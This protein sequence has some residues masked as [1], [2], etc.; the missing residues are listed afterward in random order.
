MKISASPSPLA[1]FRLV[2]LLACLVLA[3]QQLAL[4]WPAGLAG[5]GHMRERLP[6]LLAGS[7][8]GLRGA[9]VAYG[10]CFAGF[11]WALWRATASGASAG[12]RLGLLGLLGAQI[13]LALL[14]S[15]KLLLLTAAELALLLPLRAAAIGLA[16][17]LAL[18]MLAGGWQAQRL[19]VLELVCNVSGS[20]VQLPPR[21]QRGWLLWQDILVGG[22]FQLLTFGIGCLGAAERRRRAELESTRA[23]LLAARQLLAGAAGNGERLRMARELHDG[24]GHHLSALNL[25]LEL[26]LRRG[27]GEAD[28]PLR[29]AQQAARRMLAEVRALVGEERRPRESPLREALRQ[30]CEGVRPAAELSWDG[31]PG[32]DD[33]AAW[34]AFAAAREGLAGA[35]GRPCRLWLSARGGDAAELR[36]S[37][38]GGAEEWTTI[39]REAAR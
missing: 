32:L 17:Q 30:L 33:A 35:S 31:E 38:G 6:M 14:A 1:L 22:G 7:P 25:Q 19:P 29:A 2:A 39:W 27:A 16:A 34:Q 12:A 3:L 10:A 4:L 28:A 9:M 21:E 24:M 20:D 36:L 11:G 15:D 37:Y 13:G 5:V 26:L 23:S 18:A 8:L